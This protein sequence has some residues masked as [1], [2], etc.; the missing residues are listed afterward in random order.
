MSTLRNLMSE[1]SPGLSNLRL[2]S[3]RGS[4]WLIAATAVL[5]L[6]IAAAYGFYVVF[7]RG[8]SIDEGYLM[9]TVQSFLKGEALYDS[10][11]TQY[12]AFYY[13]Y[14]WLVHG[15][16]SVPLTH[17]AT[18]LLCVLHWLS[19][20]A[21]LAFAGRIITQSIVAGM[22]VFMQ[23]VKHLSP[24]ANEPGHP[25]ELV[26]ILLALGALLA[27]RDPAKPTTPALLALLGAALLF[28]K[29]NVGIFFGLALFLTMRWHASDRFARRRW[30]WLLIAGSVVLPFVLMR[31]HVM[32]DSYRNYALLGGATLLATSLAAKDLAPK[33]LQGMGRYMKLAA[34]FLAPAVVL[35]GIAFLTGTSLHG[36]I[37]GLLLTPLKTPEIGI[38]PLRV[39]NFALLSAAG[40]LVFAVLISMNPNHP[41]RQLALNVLRILFGLLGSII[42]VGNGFALLKYLLP[43]VWLVLFPAARENA[44]ASDRLFARIFLCVM[45]AWQSLQAYPIAGTQVALASFLLVLAS[46]VCLADAIYALRL[47]ERA[48][49]KFRAWPQGRILLLQTLGAVGAIYLFANVWC[50]LPDGR[51]YYASLPPLNLPGSRYV[52]TDVETTQRYQALAHYLAANSDTFLTCPG[53]NSF[54][55]WTGKRPPTHLNPTALGLLSAPQEARVLA[56]LRGARRPL[57]VVLEEIVAASAQDNSAPEGL[58]MQA[59]RQDYVEVHRIP[60]FRI[61]ALKKG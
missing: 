43:W 59:V 44:A 32:Y 34:V 5:L 39:S 17:D 25:Q 53:M 7:S 46:T 52:R 49:N 26:A 20:A 42:L 24:L 6:A 33:F 4:R 35:G 58:L 30:V 36:M 18:R 22:F 45:A 13:F 21:V 57:V 38:L 51:R 2:A 28:V 40:S 8:L 56:A 29:T 55:F 23:A 9:I 15:A 61:Y 48:H 1:E 47:P 16:L 3:S 11:F 27:T 50:G 41:R 54:Y 31:R 37:D 14:K 12:G 10:V 60:P 19:A